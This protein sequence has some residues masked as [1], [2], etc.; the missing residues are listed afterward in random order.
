M[1]CYAS[2]V[3]TVAMCPCVYLSLH[4]S[5]VKSEFYEIGLTYHHA[6]NL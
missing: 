6:T 4:Q 5:E 2:T 1:Q 3:F